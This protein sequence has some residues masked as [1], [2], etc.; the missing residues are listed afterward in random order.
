MWTALALPGAAVGNSPTE[1]TAD[2]A[3]EGGN[4]IGE[5]A[6]PGA[7]GGMVAK[8]GAIEGIKRGADEGGAKGAPGTKSAKDAW[9]A[10]MLDIDC[11]NMARREEKSVC[12]A[13][14]R[15][16]SGNSGEG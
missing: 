9:I 2:A 7:E 4:A 1:G 12:R 16:G 3:A 6:V 13:S 10:P 15:S 5:T 14:T 8:E 11:W